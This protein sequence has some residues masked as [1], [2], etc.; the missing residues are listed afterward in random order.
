MSNLEPPPNLSDP[1]PSPWRA[2]AAATAIIGASAIAFFLAGIVEWSLVAIYSVDP[3]IALIPILFAAA[4][5]HTAEILSV[6][7][8]YEIATIAMMVA[9]VSAARAGAQKL[10]GHWFD[11]YGDSTAGSLIAITGVAVMLLGW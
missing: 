7:V 3:C 5:L 8:L 2:A 10:R 11:R 4:P 9:L 6:I 1:T